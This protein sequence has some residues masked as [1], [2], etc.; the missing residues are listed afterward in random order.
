MINAEFQFRFSEDQSSLFI[1][2]VMTA[3][4]M[5]HHDQNY[6]ML[7]CKKH[8]YVL[9]NLS[10]HLCDEHK[11]ISVKKYHVIVEKYKQYK[12]AESIEM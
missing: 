10:S 2:A 1:T 11:I 12:L 6:K 8:E 7:I 5:L 3:D 9:Q 4:D